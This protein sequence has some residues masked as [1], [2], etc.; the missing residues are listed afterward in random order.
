MLDGL[1]IQTD[2]NPDY[3]DVFELA[4]RHD[5]SFYDATYLELA[6]RL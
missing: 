1:P 2:H 3:Y 6:S 4:M 5:L